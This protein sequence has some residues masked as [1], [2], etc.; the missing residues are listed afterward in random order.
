MTTAEKDS[1]SLAEVEA[2]TAVELDNIDTIDTLHDDLAASMLR[3][4]TGEKTWN[5]SEEKLV[6]RKID[7]R[8]LPILILTYGLQVS[9]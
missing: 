9:P 3:N 5:E 2:A 4:Y 6:Q 7:Y 8:L 1:R